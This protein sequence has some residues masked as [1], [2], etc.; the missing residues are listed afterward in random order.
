[1]NKQ[2]TGLLIFP[3]LEDAT[4][5]LTAIKESDA[6]VIELLDSSSIL[7][8]QR[9]HMA[10]SLL[11]DREFVEHAALLVEYEANTEKS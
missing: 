6:T 11:A 4:N 1:M 7:V 3:T 2:A 9:E 8:A 10:D 5:S